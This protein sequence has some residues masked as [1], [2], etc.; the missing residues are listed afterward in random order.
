MWT[1]SK[2]RTSHKNRQGYVL[3]VELMIPLS[4]GKD[5]VNCSNSPLSLSKILGSFLLSTQASC[6]NLQ[7][8]G[9][10]T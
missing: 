4:K 9:Q 6:P 1:Q 3:L 2:K 7:F 10:I 8:L 5:S